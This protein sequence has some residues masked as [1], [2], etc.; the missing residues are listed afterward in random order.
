MKSKLGVYLVS[1]AGIDLPGYLAAAQPRLVVSMDHNVEAWRTAK[2]ASPNTIVIGRYYVDERDQVFLDDPE[3]RAE[4]FFSAMRPEAE[5]MRGLY[6]AWVGYHESEVLT[7]DDALKLSRFYSRWG[8]LMRAAGIASC[9]YSFAAGTPELNLWPYLLDGLRSCDLLALNE[10]SAPTLDVWSSWLCLRYRR[11]IDLLPEDA[12]RPIVITE[13]GID[14]GVGPANRPQEGW[15]RF[16]DVAGYVDT[17]NW[18]DNELLCDDYVLG[19][20]V[21][22]M[23]GWGLHGSFGIYQESLIRD[24]IAQE[25]S[26]DPIVIRPAPAEDGLYSPGEDTALIEPS[27]PA[28]QDRVPDSTL[29]DQV[30]EPL[31]PPDQTAIATDSGRQVQAHLPTDESAQESPQELYSQP[32]P[33]E[34]TALPRS[35]DSHVVSAEPEPPESFALPDEVPAHLPPESLAATETPP[36]EA[37]LQVGQA[38]ATEQPTAALEPPVVEA[39]HRAEPNEATEQPAEASEL[40]TATKPPAIDVQ[41]Q[42]QAAEAIQASAAE[43][44]ESIAPQ[45]PPAGEKREQPPVAEAAKPP[46][47]PKNLAPPEPLDTSPAVYVILP[48]DTLA[49]VARKFRV[50]INTIVEANPTARS[51]RLRPGQALIIP[52]KK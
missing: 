28:H 31:A 17:L 13:T 18:Y 15:A 25:G 27:L 23:N 48:G 4:Q 47:P 1:L 6:D 51:G 10:Y 26:P 2:A 36:V 44:P 29:E 46:A 16:T 3:A 50:K 37:Q 20:A 32:P 22:A 24:Y 42:P 9:A 5:K 11:V 14:G 45:E 49:D 12:R 19:A 7:P 34:T 40:P 30:W 35:D 38:E 41:P 39:Q 33:T 21:F 43:S 52:R 8:D